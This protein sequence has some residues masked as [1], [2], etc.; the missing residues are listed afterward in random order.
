MLHEAEISGGLTAEHVRQR[1][2]AAWARHRAGRWSY[3]FFTAAT[4][5]AVELPV[6]PLSDWL[7]AADELSDV[8]EG[9][10][11]DPERTGEYEM[12]V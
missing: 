10:S 9:P 8:A 11:Q 7:A 2:L 12:A 5:L 1:T 6:C 4:V 3:A